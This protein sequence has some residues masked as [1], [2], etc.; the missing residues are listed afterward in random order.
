MIS[1][2]SDFCSGLRKAFISLFYFIEESFD[3]GDKP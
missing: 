1:L 3:F 2:I